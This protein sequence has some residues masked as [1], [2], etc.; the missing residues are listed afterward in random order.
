MTIF[1]T[2]EKFEK[3]VYKYINYQK[4]INIQV[5]KHAKV[6]KPEINVDLF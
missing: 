4:Y 6:E 3:N 2:Y 1:K 5:L